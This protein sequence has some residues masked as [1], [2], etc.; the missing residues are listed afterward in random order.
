MTESKALIHLHPSMKWLVQAQIVSSKLFDIAQ[1]ELIAA[2]SC[3]ESASRLFSKYLRSSLTDQNS[4]LLPHSKLSS[5]LSFRP[6]SRSFF[7]NFIKPTA[8]LYKGNNP[9]PISLKYAAIDSLIRGKLSY[10]YLF[11][12]P[13]IRNLLEKSQILWSYSL[14]KRYYLYLQKLK[15]TC[16]VLSHGSYS[17][18][19]SLIEASLRLNIPCLVLD[20]ERTILLRKTR[21]IYQFS[22]YILEALPHYDFLAQNCKREPWQQSSKPSSLFNYINRLSQ[23][24]PATLGSTEIPASSTLTILTHC[25]KDANYAHNPQR[26]LFPNYLDWLVYTTSVLLRHRSQYDHIIYK[27]HPSAHLYQD[28]FLLTLLGRILKLGVNRNKVT[29]LDS[30]ESVEA[31]FKTYENPIMSPLTFHGSIANEAVSLGLTPIAV[32]DALSPLGS[33]LKPLTK[34]SYQHHLIYPPALRKDIATNNYKSTATAI[35]DLLLWTQL[36]KELNESVYSRLSRFFLFGKSQPFEPVEFKT[37]L[38][39]LIANTQPIPIELESGN[40]LIFYCSN[41]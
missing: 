34:D 27:V 39:K 31:F 4:L 30:T 5:L 37:I 7:R 28:R 20:Q 36:P 1:F 8:S 41:S 35:Q 13:F 17:P 24:Q 11:S 23:K 3:Q 15:P 16:V 19:V 22:D 25:L 29:L 14:F 26:M 9:V 38:Q 21:Q 18:Y 32:G 12:P 6:F 40:T 10:L 2:P 33:T